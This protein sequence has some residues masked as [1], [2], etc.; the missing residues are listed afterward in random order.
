MSLRLAS[1]ERS[2]GTR[3]SLRQVRRWA[4]L[5]LVWALFAQ[6]LAAATQLSATVDEGFHITSGYEYLRTREVRLFDEHPPLVKALFAWPLFF[7]PDLPPPETTAAYDEGDLIAATQATTLA[8]RPLDR[9]IV[10]PR[11]ASALLTVLFAA[12]ICRLAKAL[13]GPVVSLLALALCSFDPNFIAH[14]SLATTDIGATALIFCAVWASTYWLRRPSPRLWWVTALLLGLAQGSKLTALLLYPVIG[15]GVLFARAAK[16]TSSERPLWSRLLSYIGVVVTSLLVLWALYGFELR[17][18]QGFLGGAPLPAAS[19]VERWLRLQKNLDYGREAFFLG[20][21]AMHGWPLYFPLAFIVKTPLPLLLL[22]IWALGS[23]AWCTVIHP[24]RDERRPA[25]SKAPLLLRPLAPPLLFPV[26]YLLASLTSPLNIGYRHLLPVLP[27]LYVGIATWTV[28]STRGRGVGLKKL[29]RRTRLFTSALVLMLCT[30]LA[31]GALAISPHDLAFFNELTGGPDSGWRFLADSNTDWGQT[32]KALADYQESTD[33][34]PVRL[35][36]FTFYD[37]AAYGVTY[38]PIAP[39]QGAPPVLP[40]RFSPEPGFYAISATTLDG[41]PLPYPSTYDWF[42]HRESFAKIGHAMFLYDVQAQPGTWVAQCTTPV[43][44]LTKQAL[45]EGFGTGGLREVAFDCAQAWV[46]PGGGTSPGWYVRAIPEQ[47]EL[48][49]PY[50]DPVRPEL[51][52]DWIE[53]DA[54][55][56]LELS[57][58]QPRDSALPAFAIWHFSGTS[59]SRSQTTLTLGDTLV[60]RGLTTPAEAQKGAVAEIL[61]HWE[62]LRPPSRPLSLM[63]HL[64]DISGAPIAVGD[65]LGFPLEE[66]QPGD[67]FV[68]RHQV[69]IPA[70]VASGM[71]N[72]VAGAYWLESLEPL[73]RETVTAQIRV[74]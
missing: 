34:G 9:V 30:W 15:A 44:P 58:M 52:P 31:V 33:L 46:L 17:P 18:V 35:S 5:L 40:R 2:A 59:D 47:T 45:E 67:R 24:L 19:H 38:E 50:K 27:F 20:Q 37:P 36:S 48:R 16:P 73:S 41:V 32:F 11:I 55:S 56:D 60:A 74:Q 65:A 49:W 23:W 71:Y 29:T 70:D 8:Y 3:E 63:L 61:T 28:R 69:T 54:L 4:R 53:E 62:V 57:Y 66:W 22:G 1:A 42:R 21:N 43:A 6:L 64:R 7:V 12:V 72:V 13:A 25:W 51:L 14:G 10:G 26:L 68:Q 39:M